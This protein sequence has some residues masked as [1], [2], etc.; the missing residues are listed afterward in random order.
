MGSFA[1]MFIEGFSQGTIKFGG[2]GP[3]N[4][5]EGLHTAE[6]DASRAREAERKRRAGQTQTNRS[7]KASDALSAVIGRTTLGGV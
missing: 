5:Q 7:G 3:V 6:E 4:L 1:K 2:E